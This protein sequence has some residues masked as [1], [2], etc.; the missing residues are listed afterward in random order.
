MV[1]GKAAYPY[2][3]VVIEPEFCWFQIAEIDLS[4]NGLKALFQIVFGD[5][6]IAIKSV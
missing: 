3:G 4:F 5:G 2:T 1:I 6:C